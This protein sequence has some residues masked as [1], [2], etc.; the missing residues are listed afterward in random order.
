MGRKP[1]IE[2]AVVVDAT[3]IRKGDLVFLPKEPEG[4]RTTRTHFE[5]ATIG[6]YGVSVGHTYRADN[7]ERIVR[8]K[9]TNRSGVD[10]VYL[11]TGVEE[12]R[13]RGLPSNVYDLMSNSTSARPGGPQI[14]KF[15]VIPVPDNPDPLSEE[16]RVF[17]S[18][19]AVTDN[20]KL[21]DMIGI[22]MEDL[23]V[24][25]NGRRYKLD[26]A[27]AS[28]EDVFD[29]LWGST[30][31]MMDG[32]FASN[33]R[34]GRTSSKCSVL[35]AVSGSW[36][37]C[38]GK[39]IQREDRLV[40][41]PKLVRA[42]IRNGASIMRPADPGAVFNLAVES[43]MAR[44]AAFLEARAGVMPGFVAKLRDAARLETDLRR[45]F[46]GVHA[47]VR[48]HSGWFREFIC[49]TQKGDSK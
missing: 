43:V 29:E 44:Y 3:R 28:P 2:C 4:C 37:R 47:E 22:H 23:E 30:S 12:T 10:T 35:E 13:H 18:C 1:R 19:L 27:D 6:R 48:K 49:E 5:P 34:D 24:P 46:A 9:I 7:L 14:R 16:R 31:A 38:Y 41:T 20:P 39:V 42:W 15:T 8:D 32:G 21:L 45:K 33:I 17:A 36:L 11:V 25:S 40:L 26:A